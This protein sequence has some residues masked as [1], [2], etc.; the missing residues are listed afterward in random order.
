MAC[1]YAPT[2]PPKHARRASFRL[3]RASPEQA[4]VEYGPFNLEAARD[5]AQGRAHLAVGAAYFH[6]ELAITHPDSA[7]A[8]V[9]NR[10]RELRKERANLDAALLN[11]RT[12]AQHCGE[13]Q[14]NRSGG[15]GLR[16]AGRGV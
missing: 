8:H 4:P 13:Q 3:I 1:T 6:I 12:E 5:L 9:V 7:Q 14:R 16:A 2:T 11:V 10:V 15:P